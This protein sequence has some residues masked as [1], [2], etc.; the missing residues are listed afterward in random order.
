MRKHLGEVGPNTEPVRRLL[1]RVGFRSVSRIDPFD[2][3]PHYEAR[4]EDVTLVRA[5][6]SAS[7]APE[8]LA[9]GGTEALVAVERRSGRDRFRAVRCQARQ[10][11]EGVRIPAAARR[12]LG[13]SAGDHL[14]LIPF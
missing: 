9:S 4:L 2:G 3:G 1:Q 13:A 10:F 8:P 5:H 12:L 6:R 14:H 11:H 7:L